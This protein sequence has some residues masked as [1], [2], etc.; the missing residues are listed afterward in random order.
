MQRVVPSAQ[1]PPTVVLRVAVIKHNQEAFR[2]AVLRGIHFISVAV[3][4]R[5][6]THIESTLHPHVRLPQLPVGQIPCPAIRKP[7]RIAC[8]EPVG[9]QI[10]ALRRRHP[11]VVERHVR[12]P[13][14][15]ADA[16]CTTVPCRHISLRQREVV[17]QHVVKETLHMRPIDLDTDTVRASRFQASGRLGHCGFRPVRADFHAVLRIVPSTQVPPTIILRVA[18]VKDYQETFGPACLCGLH[19]IGVAFAHRHAAHTD[20]AL[21]AHF[22]LPQLSVGDAPLAAIHHPLCAEAGK[23]VAHHFRAG[24]T[25]RHPH[26]VKRGCRAPRAQADAARSGSQPVAVLR[27]FHIFLSHVVGEQLLHVI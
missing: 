19:F 12:A 26:I 23:I 4:G 13:R 7:V 5:K 14:A 15:Q 16:L 3:A 27:P 17:H 1:V 10:R 25:V 9:K 24:S 11:H 22:R 18:I 8:L 21:H 20:P 2:P 6:V